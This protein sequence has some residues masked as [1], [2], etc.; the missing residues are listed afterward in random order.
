[1]MDGCENFSVQRSVVPGLYKLR[2]VV[3]LS[4]LSQTNN[5]KGVSQS[6]MDRKRKE[7]WEEEEKGE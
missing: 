3:K 7:R 6:N 4:S 5:S 1:M 2:P